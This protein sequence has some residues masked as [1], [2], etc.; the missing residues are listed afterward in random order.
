MK[1]FIKAIPI[2]LTIVLLVSTISSCGTNK[3]TV[4]SS[5]GSSNKPVTITE[6]LWVDNNSYMTTMNKIADDF[7]KK[8]P[9]ITVKFQT[10]AYADFN[11]VLNTALAGGGGP[12]TASFKLTW[13][14]A[15][16]QNN[17]L[18]DLDTSVS[19]WS[20]KSDVLPM[21]WD[22]MKLAGT[23]KI[24]T[25]PWTWQVLYVYYRPSIFSHVGIASVPTTFDEFLADI[26]KCT[27]KINGKQV[28]GF[29]LRGT[30]GGQE[31]WG[32]FIQA[33]GGRFTDD[34]GNVTLN[35]PQTVAGT[36]AF[37]DLYK[38]G[39]APPSAPNDGLAQLEA[40]FITGQTAM[41][42]HHI[43]SSVYLQQALGTDVNAFPVPAGTGG[44]WTSMGDTE[45]VVIASTKNQDASVKW[46]SYLASEDAVAAWDLATGNLPVCQSVMSLPDFKYNKF[47]KVSLDSASYSGIFPILPTTAD[48]VSNQWAPIMQQALNGQITAAEAVK[49]LDAK[50]KG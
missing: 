48:W 37:I 8:N 28:Y 9:N 35:T 27:T 3:G 31:P 30:S 49:Q 43:G 47:M 16:T 17:Y 12:D 39:Y 32:S 23:G 26:K 46:V 40:S 25:M 11:N 13:T 18:L 33:Y 29:G 24:Y 36:Q 22:K 41:F 44:Q 7:H 50:L 15:Y 6:W 2:L 21:L 4:N 34:K 42:I 10:Y 14:P 1:R 45:N 20:G 19:K 38:N 5:S